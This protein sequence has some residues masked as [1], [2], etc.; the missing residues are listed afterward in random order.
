MKIQVQKES[1]QNISLSHNTSCHPRDIFKGQ[2]VQLFDNKFFRA[3]NFLFAD[4]THNL[5][6][7]L[8]PKSGDKICLSCH[9]P[10]FHTLCCIRNYLIECPF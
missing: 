9:F 7:F 6:H 2:V 1:L 4:N 3:Q 5:I 10:K 8:F